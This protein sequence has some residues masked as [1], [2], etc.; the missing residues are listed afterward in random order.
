MCKAGIAG[1]DAPTTSFPAIVGRFKGNT[2]MLG[3][4]NKDCL[5]GDEA[6]A[7]KGILN[8]RYPIEH[9]VVT[10]WEDME[11]IWN[12]CKFFNL[13]YLLI[14]KLIIRLF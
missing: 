14:I 11:K 9:G 12:H 5:I 10:N 4:D 7:K 2:A 1:E 8:L 3:L 6:L 13:F